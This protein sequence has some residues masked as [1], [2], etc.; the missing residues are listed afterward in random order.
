MMEI[1]VSQPKERRINMWKK[2]QQEK[3]KKAVYQACTMNGVWKKDQ[4]QQRSSSSQGLR[5][6]RNRID[7]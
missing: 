4:T 3:E 7:L 6:A 1:E 5:V 2:L